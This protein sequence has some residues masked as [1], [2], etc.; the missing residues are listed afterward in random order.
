MFY[1]NNKFILLS[2]S[3]IPYKLGVLLEGYIQT[4]QTQ[5]A[6]SDK[7]LHVLLTQCSINALIKMKND[8]SDTFHSG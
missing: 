3:L 6:A 2:Y 4:V 7:R 5:N 1:T 8:V